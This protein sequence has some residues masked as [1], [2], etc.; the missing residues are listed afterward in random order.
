MKESS[1]KMTPICVYAECTECGGEMEREYTD[2][3]SRHHYQCDCGHHDTS[4]TKYP[5]YIIGD[6]KIKVKNL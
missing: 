6:H 1:K 4:E 3:Y 2:M 5:Y